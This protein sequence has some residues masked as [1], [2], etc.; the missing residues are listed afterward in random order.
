MDMKKTIHKIKEAFKAIAVPA[1]A[2][3]LVICMLLGTT[4]V[5]AEESDTYSLGSNFNVCIKCLARQ[6]DS[7]IASTSSE[8]SKIKKIIF[9]HLEPDSYTDTCSLD[10][11]S[12]SHNSTGEITAYW[13]SGSRTMYI[14]SEGTIK[15][16]V[17]SGHLFFKLKAVESIDLSILDTSDAVDMH[18]MFRDC[19]AL[20]S[21]DISGFDTSN[22]TTMNAIFYGCRKLESADLTGINTSS[23]TNM[24][25]MFYQCRALQGLD[26]SSFDTS[27]VSNFSYMFAE[28]YAISGIDVT[29]FDTSSAATMTYMFQGCQELEYLDVSGFDTSGV[30]DMEYMFTNCKK[31]ETIDVSG[32]DTSNVT[33]FDYMFAGCGEVTTLDVSGFD[34]SSAT[35]MCYMFADCAKVT[36]LDVSGFVTS[37]VEDM[38]CMFYG[39]ASVP[40]I[41]CSNFD[42]SFVYD[43]SAMF[44]G[45]SSASE[46]RTGSFTTPDTGGFAYMFYGCE[47]LLA[48]DLSGF[49]MSA[50]E[51]CSEMFGGC[52]SLSRILTPIAISEEVDL[53][54]LFYDRIDET[55]E[56]LPESGTADEIRSYPW[57]SGY[58]VMFMPNGGTGEMEEAHFVCGKQETLPANAFTREGY[59]FCGW[60]GSPYADKATY[61]D[62]AKVTD[63]T[64]EGGFIFLYAIWSTGSGGQTEIE[65]DVPSTYTV[66][67]PAMVRLVENRSGEGKSGLAAGY[68]VSVSGNIAEDEYVNVVPD[69]ESFILRDSTGARQIKP[70]IRS[71]AVAWSSAELDSA[72]FVD[73]SVMVEADRSRAGRYAGEIA[74]TFWLSKEP[75]DLPE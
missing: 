36:E 22:V 51:D 31:L 4:S 5:L 15:A 26:L 69:S 44:L 33:L 55:Y 19:A 38:N 59:S 25:Y 6:A 12:Y 24:G 52:I 63:L 40:L 14:Y 67:L 47:E 45:C 57:G 58:T 65:I 56:T 37:D 53:P 75:A 18:N 2:A 7:N 29:S 8:D 54:A 68:M 32:F 62:K 60:A 50:A 43:M 46:I 64:S 48:L 21:I 27:D 70:V 10:G 71:S 20:R 72:G 28:C 3:L 13:D 39:C 61:A 1:A 16:P 73:R 66:V 74:Y 41:D 35:D 17:D 30:R 9:T 42:T 23:V 11:G 34:T 49:D